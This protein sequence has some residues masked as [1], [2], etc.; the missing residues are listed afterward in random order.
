MIKFNL[1]DKY[2]I[3][4]IILSSLTYINGTSTRKYDKY[5]YSKFFLYHKPENKEH[6]KN[7]GETDSS[8][9]HS[10]TQLRDPPPTTSLIARLSFVHFGITSIQDKRLSMGLIYAKP[11]TLKD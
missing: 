6:S 7:K 4:K 5:N 3:S 8:P 2:T 9:S 1:G 11:Y 10:P